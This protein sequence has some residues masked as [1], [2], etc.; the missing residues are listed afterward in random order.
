MITARVLAV[1]PHPDQATN[2]PGCWAVQLRV[3]LRKTKRTFWRWHTVR[4]LDDI[5]RY[6]RP[7]NDKKPTHREIL[8]RFWDDT[9]GELHGFDFRDEEDEKGSTS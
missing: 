4:Q 1:R 2:N 6:V 5:G 7:S 9:F 8:D 3:S